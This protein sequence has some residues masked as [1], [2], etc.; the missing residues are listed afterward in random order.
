MD[1]VGVHLYSSNPNLDATFRLQLERGDTLTTFEAGNGRVWASSTGSAGTVY[2]GTLDVARGLL[3]V[4]YGQIAS[5]N[6]ETLPGA[7]LS[8]K[9]TYTPGGTPTAGA[10][11]VYELAAPLT[12]QLTPQQIVTLDG[13]NNVF[14]DCGSVTVTHWPGT[15]TPVEP[16]EDGAVAAQASV[17][18]GLEARV[19]ALENA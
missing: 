3:T 4:T 10:Q 18:A 2:G 14:A 8:S 11:V 6:G 5:Y 19:A 16:V 1:I 9:D 15:G 17:I 13:A 7:W 12:Y